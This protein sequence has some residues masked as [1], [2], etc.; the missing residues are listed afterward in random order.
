[1]TAEFVHDA[2]KATHKMHVLQFDLQKVNADPDSNAH[3][4]SVQPPHSCDVIKMIAPR[5]T[6]LR[7][8]GSCQGRRMCR[9]RQAY[10]TRSTPL[11]RQAQRWCWSSICRC[12]RL[13][14]C[15]TGLSCHARPK[16]NC[17]CA[18]RTQIP[19]SQHRTHT[20]RPG[21]CHGR[22]SPGF[23]QRLR[24]TRSVGMEQWWQAWLQGTG[25]LPT[26]LARQCHCSTCMLLNNVNALPRQDAEL[27]SDTHTL[28][29][30]DAVACVDDTNLLAKLNAQLSHPRQT[31]CARHSPALRTLLVCS[32]AICWRARSPS[33]DRP[34][35][36]L[37]SAA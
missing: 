2:A 13:R 30:N 9:K 12:R 32:T 15:S 8:P 18:H 23:V 5:S 24:K 21:M 26:G 22:C 11:L 28:L 7:H 36:Q 37:V 27:V 17:W 20:R 31:Q 16:R 4:F 1:M 34:R 3:P 10:L 6:S 19:S 33:S 29:Q 35:R 14:S 25:C